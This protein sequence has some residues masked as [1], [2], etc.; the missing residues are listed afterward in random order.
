VT[1][2][3]AV[4]VV[5]A[6]VPYYVCDAGYPSSSLRKQ[7]T[8]HEVTTWALAKRVLNWRPKRRLFSQ[9]ATGVGSDGLFSLNLMSQSCQK[10][11]QWPGFRVQSVEAPLGVMG[12]GI[13]EEKIIGV[14]DTGGKIIRIR[15]IWTRNVTICNGQLNIPKF[16]RFLVVSERFN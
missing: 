13:F 8:F 11:T 10:L 12:Y 3:S 1:F 2:S 16:S 5:F 14:R 15:D 6:W 4:A 7:P 9:P